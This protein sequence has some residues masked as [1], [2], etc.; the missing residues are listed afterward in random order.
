MDIIVDYLRRP[1][2]DMKANG[3]LH[4]VRRILPSNNVQQV[5][6]LEYST[7]IDYGVDH[8][9]NRMDPTILRD[10]LTDRTLLLAPNML[11]LKGIL[12]FRSHRERFSEPVHLDPMVLLALSLH[13][14]KD[15][16]QVLELILQILPLWSTSMGII[17]E[18]APE[19]PCHHHHQHLHCE[20][21][22]HIPRHNLNPCLVDQERLWA[23]NSKQKNHRLQLTR[24]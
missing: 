10:L 12:V 6:R 5:A 13:P 7:S 23:N 15:I 3:T 4:T 16:P 14:D 1:T 19:S 24:K 20:L 9:N 17:Q 2:K 18:Q 11:A 22:D 8:T 21:R